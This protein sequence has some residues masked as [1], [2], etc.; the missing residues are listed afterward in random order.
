M[1][2]V[3]VP[4]FVVAVFEVPDVFVLDV[5]VLDVFVDDVFDVSTGHDTEACCPAPPVTVVQF[6]VDSARASA[7]RA[8]C[9][10]FV[11]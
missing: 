1:V 5:F 7:C 11:A 10:C 4:V 8:S 2:W 3:V 9:S 6:L